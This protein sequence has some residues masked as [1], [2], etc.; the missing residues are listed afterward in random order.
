MI[1]HFVNFLGT[2]QNEWAGAQA[3]SSFDTYMAP[4][5]RNDGMRYDQVRQCIQE[6]I[7]NLN[8]PSRWGTQTPFTNLTFDWTCP[9]DLR[10]QMTALRCSTW[11]VEAEGAWD[12]YLLVGS[13]A[14]LFALLCLESQRNKCVLIGE[15][16][17]TV[18]PEIREAMAR[19]QILRMYCQQ[20]RMAPDPKQPFAPVPPESICSLNT[21]DMPPFA[22]FWDGLDLDDKMKLGYFTPEQLEQKKQDRKKTREILMKYLTK[23]KLLKKAKE[24]SQL[25]SA[26]VETGLKEQDVTLRGVHAESS[27]GILGK[28]TSA[29]Y[30][31]RVRCDE[32][33]KLADV[34]EMMKRQDPTFRA[35]ESEETGQTIISGMGELHLDIIVDRMKREFNVQANVGKPQVAYRE[36]IRKPSEA[37]GN[38]PSDGQ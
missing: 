35:K 36:T 21:H 10:D 37:E 29:S 28:S 20:R 1:W 7:Y 17:G 15:D 34:L 11:W 24:V 25:I 31:L 16:L 8:V 9:E 19:H 6:L 38:M 26:L 33:E 18:P 30:Q 13:S 27:S 4:F 22:A 14:A 5:I 23:L 12:G 3:F 32:L 2:L